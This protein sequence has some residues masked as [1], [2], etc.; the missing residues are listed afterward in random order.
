MNVFFIMHTAEDD[1][2]KSKESA[3]EDSTAEGG[4]ST[5]EGGKGLSHAQVC[6]CVVCVSFCHLCF[7]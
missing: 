6:V 7:H 4:D 5:K 1:E 3:D 2:E